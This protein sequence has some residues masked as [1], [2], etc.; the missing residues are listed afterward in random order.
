[1]MATYHEAGAEYTVAVK[2]APEAVLD[3]VTRVA[4]EDG[5]EPLTADERAA[6]VE[7][8]RHM[9]EDGYRV[10]ALARKTV[11]SPE[12]PPYEELT[13]LGLVG[14]IDPPREE[15]KSTIQRCQ[16]AGLRVIM[17]TG[18]H[19]GTATNVARS[20]GLV[21]DSH[22]TV[23]EG[24]E[25]AGEGDRSAEQ[26]AR[27]REAAVFA[28]VAPENKLDLIALHQQAG[29]IV[30]MTGDGVNDAP[31][32]KAADIGVAMGKRGTQVARE[33]ADMVLRDDN[34]T[35]IY[36][37]IREGR[38]IFRN[39]RRFV[40]YLLS[41]NLSELLTILFASLLGFPLPLLPLQILF[42]NIVND[43][44]PAFAL[45]AS[46]GSEEIMDRPPRDPDEPILTRT[47]WTELG[48]YGSLIA[49][50]TIVAFVVG[51]RMHPG[52]MGSETVV[53]MSFLTL[54]FAQL[55]HVF[56]MREPGSGLLRNEV[57]ENPY[58]WGA[59]GLSALLVVAT[60]YLPGVSLALKT[61]PIDL[62]SWAVVLG[63]S[64]LPLL[65]GQVGLELR[66]RFDVAT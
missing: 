45:G 66:R 13:L 5:T 37:A 38:I 41:C 1:M 12:E 30:A 42:L 11:S 35:S 59:L 31:A 51:A 19:A 62:E 28:R 15:V 36:H 10:L 54:A 47:V 29:S 56:N 44:F 27:L 34:F 17:V 50:A 8:G 39:I 63:A 7:R 23:I 61:T 24:A 4:T 20:V 64:L 40:L 21:E 26:T 52:G 9:A 18:D 57:T 2:G 46:G 60:L 48:V 32:L 58:V 65:V 22:E 16:R 43:I 25:L 6:W 33:A 14:L 3:G 55:W 49:V 53:T